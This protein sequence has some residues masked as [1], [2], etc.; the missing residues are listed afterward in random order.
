MDKI[1]EIT[2]KESLKGRLWTKSFIALLITQ[3]LVSLNDNIFRWLIVPIGKCAVGWSD[4]PDLIRTAGAL[5]FLVPFLAF[6][7][8]AG[9]VTDRYDRRGVIIWC[10]I[11]EIIIMVFGTV[12]ILSQSVP[13][14]LV[15]LF[16]MGAQSAFFSPAKYS[17][18]PSLVPH[19]RITEAN[20]YYSMTTMIACIA[21]QLLGGILFVW[22]TFSPESPV[23][24]TGG[25]AL[26][27]VWAGVL[28]GVSVAGLIASLFVP[29]MPSVDRTIRF[30]WNPFLQ[31]YKDLGFLFRHRYLFWVALGS[32]FFWG[33][34]ALAQ[35]NI[36]KFATEILH[37]RQ[38]YAMSLLVALTLGLAGGALLAGRLSRGKV[39]MGLSPIGAM[40]LVLFALILSFTPMVAIPAGAHVASPLTFG[41]LFGAVGLFCMGMSAGMY[42]IPLMTTLQTESPA[43]SRGR[44]LAASNFYSFSGMAIFSLMQGVLAMPASVGLPLPGLSANGIWL[45][46]ALISIPVCLAA[47][48][49]L[50]IPLLRVLVSFW[51]NLVY[52]PRIIDAF[53]VPETGP[54]L[55]VSNHVSYLDA[56]LIYCSCHRNIRFIAHA[57]YVPKCFPAYVA[58]RTGLI[59]IIPGNRKSIV[60]MV[61]T[62]REALAQGEVVA[63]FPEGAITRTGQLRA[64]EPGFLSILKGHDDVPVIPVFIGGTW[65]S[66]FAYG[67]TPGNRGRIRQR[68]TVAF[69][70]P[71]YR[72]RDAQQVQHKVAELGVDAMDPWRFP[73]DPHIPV[74]ARSMIRNCHRFP[75]LFRIADST[76]LELNGRQTL[77]RSLV[78]RRILRRVLGPDE[79]HVGLLIPT[80]V[81]GVLANAALVL[82]RRVPVNMNFTF[83]N[84]TNNYCLHLAGIKKILTTKRL[85]QRLP[86]LKLDAEFIVLEDI[87][88]QARLGDK[89]VGALEAFLPAWL[90]ERLLGLTQVRQDDLNTIV[91]TSGSTGT[92]KGVMLTHSNIM[93]NIESFTELYRIGPQDRL[94]A[95]LPLFHSYGYSTTTWFPLVHS[96]SC[97]YHFSP[98]D[99]KAIGELGKKYR[100]TILASTPT[101]F[102]NYLR[103]CPKECFESVTGP[104][105]GAEKLPAELVEKWKEKYGTDLVEGF[106]VT[107]LSP[108]LSCNIVPPRWP[109][110]YHVY[111]KPGSVGIP[112]ASFVVRI[113]DLTTGEELPANQEGMLEVKG[114]SVMKGYYGDPERTKA[115]FHDG[116]YITGDI[117]KLDEDGF[118]FITGRESRMSKIGGEMVPHILIEER[119]TKIIADAE[120]AAG[121]T[122]EPSGDESPLIPLVVTSVPDEI[123]GEKIVV[124]YTHMP[125]TPE[126]MCKRLL[127]SG[128]PPLWVPHHAN[129]RQID[130]IPLLGT[131]KL[132]L[133]AI[134]DKALELYAEK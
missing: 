128:C 41:F 93:A 54:A 69:G 78:L 79:R 34:G 123:K 82:D 75:R 3:F 40:A 63:I 32:A 19:S 29:S 55:L 127:S 103:R 15:M 121:V 57:D 105:T 53:R 107:E 101:F 92:P 48:Y 109:D 25:M 50:F 6:T 116:W 16:L 23:E 14:M 89:L 64:F 56:L 66:W 90:L 47:G 49:F 36:D 120:K 2:E 94:L 26:W 24:G 17:A 39:E 125:F 122:D 5:A 9:Y 33:L 10:K 98:L 91:F 43:A 77:L 100:P 44:I 18:L 110:S 13:F 37:V 85:L 28:I 131:G 87:L 42:D 60:Q 7:S 102:R 20:G 113:T 61:R 12:A 45:F 97:A 81:G 22:T 84:E 67:K 95:T 1:A 112:S 74:P 104:V 65:G 132:N 38:D 71:I 99:S 119:L 4:S 11:A 46:C 96:V 124:L 86:N 130:V 108:V 106:G 126:E 133:K 114:A 51:L 62:A 27:P 118:I 117:A 8:Y 88:P 31:T 52:R 83:S 21:G 80:S 76:G 129:F 111:A 68:M 35:L 115:A 73:N 58:K 59:T 134:K 72:P 30:P 70:E